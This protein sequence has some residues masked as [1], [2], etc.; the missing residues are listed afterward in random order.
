MMSVGCMKWTE[1]GVMNDKVPRQK[2]YLH[3]KWRYPRFESAK[4]RCGYILYTSF[5]VFVNAYARCWSRVNA[6]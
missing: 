1:R 2:V 5:G 3:T 4:R 6:S